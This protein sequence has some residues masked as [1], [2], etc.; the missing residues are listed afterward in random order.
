L[1][2][3]ENIGANTEGSNAYEQLGAKFKTACP[4]F[5]PILSER[6]D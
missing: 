3:R 4:L 5:R 6:S 1:A 2:L